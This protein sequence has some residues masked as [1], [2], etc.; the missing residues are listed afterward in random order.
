MARGW[1][2]K[3]VE[4]QVESSEHKPVLVRTKKS[5]EGQRR[6]A[7]EIQ[8]M[9]ER[10]NLELARAKVVH[11]LEATQSPRY[12]EMLNRALRELDEKLS[13]LD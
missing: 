12:A 3:S 6:S 13:K 5:D 8:G 7:A 10:R 4:A 2:S 11:E 1:E 9:I